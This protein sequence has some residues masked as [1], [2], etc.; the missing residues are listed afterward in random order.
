M[1]RFSRIFL[2]INEKLCTPPPPLFSLPPRGG[3]GNSSFVKKK[4][5]EIH[6]WNVGPAVKKRLM[7][8]RKTLRTVSWPTHTIPSTTW[9]AISKNVLP[10]RQR[11]ANNNSNNTLHKV[12]PSDYVWVV[13]SHLSLL[14]VTARRR[15]VSRATI[16]G[17]AP[18]PNRIL[19]LFS[20]PELW[21]APKITNERHSLVWCQNKFPVLHFLIPARCPISPCWLFTVWHSRLRVRYAPFNIIPYFEW[22]GGKEKCFWFD[23]R[24][25]L[26]F[27]FLF[28]F[29]CQRPCC[30]SPP[31]SHR[32]VVVDAKQDGIYYI[33]I[34]Y[35][36][37]S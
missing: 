3:G 26:Y 25:G 23:K 29:N 17:R 15:D 19:L 2:I 14:C 31:A 35:I 33:Y 18:P 12:N 8:G 9:N 24:F 13:E 11:N 1:T 21:T 5:I 34:I 7:G 36:F 37:F 22:K 27:V 20:L 28:F 32:D 10:A 30:C 16:I 4:K 6:N